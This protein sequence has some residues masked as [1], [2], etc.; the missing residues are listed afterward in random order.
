MSILWH[1]VESR[2]ASHPVPQ[3][4]GTRLGRKLNHALCNMPR[5]RTS[6]LGGFA[7]LTLRQNFPPAGSE[8]APIPNKRGIIDIV[9]VF[10]P[11]GLHLSELF[12]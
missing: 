10:A 4:I 8:K 11:V 2:G 9:D 1:D 12:L 3:P 6:G 5:R 7:C